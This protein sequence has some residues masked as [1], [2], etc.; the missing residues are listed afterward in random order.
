MLIQVSALE[1]FP[2]NTGPLG[3]TCG[4]GSSNRRHASDRQFTQLFNYILTRHFH[5]LDFFLSTII[6]ITITLQPHRGKIAL[7]YHTNKRQK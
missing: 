1:A 3:F 4:I 2:K 6:N 5:I 7:L